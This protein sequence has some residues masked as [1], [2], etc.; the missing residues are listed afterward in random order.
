MKKIWSVKTVILMLAVFYTSLASAQLLAIKRTN[1]SGIERNTE[2][3]YMLG[4]PNNLTNRNPRIINHFTKNY[5]APDKAEWYGV[6]D[7]MVAKFNRD[8]IPHAVTYNNDGNWMYTIKYY[9]KQYVPANVIAIV[10]KKF[11]NFSILRAREVL[12]PNI[13]QSIYLVQI[14]NGNHYK[15]L[16]IN[17]EGTYVLQSLE[18]LA[19]AR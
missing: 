1:K 6:D 11:R 16:R 3:F 2:P 19:L 17:R 12:V 15:E 5:D 9:T 4:N 10:N 14:Q 13:S 8:S 18:T 7:G